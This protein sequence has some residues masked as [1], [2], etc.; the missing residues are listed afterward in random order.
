MAAYSRLKALG[1]CS[2]FLRKR[3]PHAALHKTPSTA[4][5]A[6]AILADGLRLNSAAI[7]SSV[8]TSVFPGLVL[9]EEGIQNAKGEQGVSRAL[10][11]L[12]TQDRQLHAILGRIRDWPYTTYN[13]SRDRW[14]ESSSPTDIATRR[15]REWVLD[16]HHTFNRHLTSTQHRPSAIARPRG[17]PRRIFCP[18]GK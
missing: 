2:N 17:L 12:L 5:A 4:A 1:Q 15:R 13:S 3:I 14:Q 9:L 7:C 11:H 16:L 8:C 10:I 6:E 18:A